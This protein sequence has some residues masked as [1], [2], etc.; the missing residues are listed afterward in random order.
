MYPILFG[1][2][3]TLR[4]RAVLRLGISSNRTFIYFNILGPGVQGFY[5]LHF[6]GQAG[7]VGSPLP[8]DLFLYLIGVLL[9]LV[10]SSLGGHQEGDFVG[11]IT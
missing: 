9:L 11:I 6:G 1:G 4:P 3:E 7:G 10:L 2:A 5:R 8:A